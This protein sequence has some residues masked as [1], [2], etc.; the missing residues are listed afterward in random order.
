MT[1]SGHRAAFAAAAV[2]DHRLALLFLPDHADDD[3]RDDR[4]KHDTDND[5]P[6]IA[7]EPLDHMLISLLQSPFS[8][9]AVA[10]GD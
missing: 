4:G 8:K 2:A 5:C 9:G 1:S 7:G 6:D 3:R 10:K